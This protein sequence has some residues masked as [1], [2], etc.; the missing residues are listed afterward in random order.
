[1]IARKIINKLHINYSIVLR[2]ESNK[3][4][5]SIKIKVPSL[6]KDGTVYEKKINNKLYS[7]K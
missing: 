2:D 5:F 4:Y 3:T 7:L 1:M 6:N